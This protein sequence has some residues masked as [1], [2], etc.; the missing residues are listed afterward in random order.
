MHDAQRSGSAAGRAADRPPQ[1]IVGLSTLN[2]RYL[3][4]L[5]VAVAY[6]ELTVGISELG[7]NKPSARTTRVRLNATP[8]R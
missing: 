7:F 2:M 1:P 6:R 8:R 3:L 4:A 5:T